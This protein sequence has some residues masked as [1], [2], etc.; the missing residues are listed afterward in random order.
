IQ[1]S[2]GPEGNPHRSVISFVYDMPFGRGKRFANSLHP[3]LNLILG[4]WQTNGILTFRSGGFLSADSSVNNGAGGRQ[5]NRADATGQ[6]ANLPT[7]Q[8]TTGRWFNTAAF[9][10]PWYTRFGT[11]GVGVILGPGGSNWDLSIFKNTRITE[12]INLQ[13]RTE[14]FNAF[15]HVNLNNP[16]TNVSNRS[17]FGTITGAAAARIIQLGLKLVF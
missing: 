5:Q 17:T 6:A 12:G 14:M 11:S 13:F 8:R 4:G 16:A 1:H 3:A 15:N 9:I 10:D 7:D 2:Y